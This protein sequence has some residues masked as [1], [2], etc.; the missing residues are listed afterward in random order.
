MYVF[1]DTLYVGT[2]FQSMGYDR[3]YDAGPAAL[4][5]IRIHPDDSWELIVGNPRR[6]FEGMK[7]P[8]ILDIEQVQIE[9]KRYTLH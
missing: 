6:T 2:G 1:K 4:E 7:F 5:L 9:E 3:T 8:L